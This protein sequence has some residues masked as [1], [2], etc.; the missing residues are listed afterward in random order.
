MVR[1]GQWLSEGWEMTKS[2][3]INYILLALIVSIGGNVTGGI[4]TGPLMVGFFYVVFKRMRN[5]SEPITVSEVSKG[6]E[7]FVPALLAAIVSGLF[8]SVGF[9]LCIVPGFFVAAMYLFVYPLILEK[10]L[11][12]WQAMETS[13]KK[14]M[15]NLVGFTGFVLAVAGVQLLGALVFG[16]GTL[17][18]TPTILCAL[19]VAYRDVFGLEAETAPAQPVEPPAPT[20]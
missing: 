17:V 18:T 10:R 14:V 9:V 4:L 8:I 19:A 2:D 5:P 20:A 15:E 1:T 12:F 6:F 3:L 11:D 13:R 16:V 7:F